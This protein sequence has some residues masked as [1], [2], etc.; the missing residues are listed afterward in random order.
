M[1]RYFH[2]QRTGVSGFR[3]GRSYSFG[4]EQNFF[5]RDLFGVEVLVPVA[6][7]EGLPVD[8]LIRDH[9]DPE[10]LGHFKRIRSKTITPDQK[11]LLL[12]ALSVLGLQA[13]LLRELLFEQVRVESFPDTPSRLKGIWLIPH[14]EQM[15]AAWCA[16]AP[17]GQFRAFEL[18]ATGRFHRGAGRWLK[19]E[20]VSAATLREN[21]RRYW[22]EPATDRD[23][24]FE[25]LCEGEI[26]VLRELRMPG[27]R[28]TAW[29]KLKSLFK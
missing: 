8:H 17:H 18:E 12:S 13:M 3:V 6:G 20:C 7:T 4:A 24:N 5:A 19:P 14:D 16:T 25:I 27:S 29:T 23:P 15:L 22:S 28:Q 1:P 11:G 9:L 21:A 2:V 26:T 10:G